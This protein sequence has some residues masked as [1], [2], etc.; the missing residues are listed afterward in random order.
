MATTLDGRQDQRAGESEYL[1]TIDDLCVTYPAS[2]ASPGGVAALEHIDLDVQAGEF[3][4][5]VGPSGCGK[6]TLLSTVGGLLTGF[7]GRISVRGDSIDGPH[8]DVGVVFQEESTFPWRSVLKNVEFGLEMR[9]EAKADRR[10][11]AMEMLAM[12]G[13]EDFAETYPGH[14]S[15][16]MKQRVAI[17]RTLVMEPSILLM[18]EPFGALDEQTRIILG[19]ELLRIQRALD[20]TVLLI[21]HNIQEAI[22]L[23]DRVVVLSARPGRI[24]AVVDVDLPKQRDSTLLATDEFAGLVGQVWS[25]LRDESL[26]AFAQEDRK[27]EEPT[28]A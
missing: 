12:V 9:G 20:Q 25:V 18:D 16:G 11:R 24:K 14:L 26:K 3:V 22:L 27:N 15:G 1:F 23:S 5:V 17:A 6:S 7:D 2:A 28:H 13:L 10:R 4:S 8:P 19:E 21:T